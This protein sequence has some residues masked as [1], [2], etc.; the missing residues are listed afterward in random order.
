[1][2]IAIHK[3]TNKPI[4][5]EINWIYANKIVMNGQRGTETFDRLVEYIFQSANVF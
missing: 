5:N 4:K 1:M 3:E 2:K